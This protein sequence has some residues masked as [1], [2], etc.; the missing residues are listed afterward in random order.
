M[1]IF[2]ILIN[3][4]VRL[5]DISVVYWLFSKFTLERIKARTEAGSRY[6]SQMKGFHQTCQP[7]ASCQ[8][9]ASVKHLESQKGQN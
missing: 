9:A 5:P 4:L 3:F 1:W 6:S 2:H 8:P 7:N